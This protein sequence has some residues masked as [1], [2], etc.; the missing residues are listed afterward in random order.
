MISLLHMVV[1]SMKRA[2][3]YK[4]LRMAPVFLL[5]ACMVAS[6]FSHVLP[7]VKSFPC[8]ICPLQG[9][10]FLRNSGY[11]VVLQ[12]Q[13]SDGH[14]KNYDFVDYVAFSHF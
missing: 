13:P 4:A 14:K 11:S 9:L 7:E 8:P 12:S 3:T 10:D 6:S 2:N 5:P 1:S